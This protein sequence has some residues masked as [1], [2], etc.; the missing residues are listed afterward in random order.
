[1]TRCTLLEMRNDV[2]RYEILQKFYQNYQSRQSFEFQMK[3]CS[4]VNS[5]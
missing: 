1:M 2:G 3:V 4:D 5:I